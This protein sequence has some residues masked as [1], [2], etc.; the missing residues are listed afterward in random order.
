MARSS[1]TVAAAIESVN[2]I[3]AEQNAALKVL[4][5]TLFQKTTGGVSLTDVDVYVGDFQAAENYALILGSVDK[6][7]DI[8]VS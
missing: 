2:G 5:D 4:K 7:W 3:I 6:Y 1:E 8:L